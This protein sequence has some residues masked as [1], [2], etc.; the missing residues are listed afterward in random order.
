MQPCASSGLDATRRCYARSPLLD[1]IFIPHWLSV[2]DD[3]HQHRRDY[4]PTGAVSTIAID[5]APLS[6]RNN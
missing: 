2:L 1:T 5:G 4:G 6:R 3:F